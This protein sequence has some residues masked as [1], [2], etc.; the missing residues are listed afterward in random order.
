MNRSYSQNAPF[1]KMKTRHRFSPF[2]G[3]RNFIHQSRQHF[4]Q[5]SLNLV[6][7][8]EV[9]MLKWGVSERWDADEVEAGGT[10]IIKGKE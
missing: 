10:K 1:D 2:W 4:S 7:D 6:L 3:A 8:S 9:Q 5:G